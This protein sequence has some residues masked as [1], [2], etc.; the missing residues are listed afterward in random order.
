MRRA[1]AVILFLFEP[2]LAAGLLLRVGPTLFDRDA[3][4]VVAFAA[5]VVLALSSMAAAIGLRDSRP[6][7]GRLA[8]IVLIASAAFAVF[9]YFTRALPTSLAPDVAALATGIIVLHH[10]TWVAILGILDRKTG[11]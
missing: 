11:D 7:A 2:I 10:G 3:L 4:T 9:Q 1:L 6:W 8:L 5:R